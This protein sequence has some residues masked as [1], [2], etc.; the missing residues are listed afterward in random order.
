L[1]NQVG[2]KVAQAVADFFG[3][4]KFMYFCLHLFL[5]VAC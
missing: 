4:R 2:S 5:P 1:K 3:D